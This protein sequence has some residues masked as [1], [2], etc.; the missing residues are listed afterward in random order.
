M[1]S[2]FYLHYTLFNRVF[3]EIYLRTLIKFILTEVFLHQ[4]VKQ[5]L[6]LINGLLD[7]S[8]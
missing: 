1:F 4:A 2:L 6:G 5:H 3:Q 7:D 8:F